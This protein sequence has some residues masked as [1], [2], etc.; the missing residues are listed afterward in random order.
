M[1]K[2]EE[3]TVCDLYDLSKYVNENN[4][5]LKPFLQNP[6]DIDKIDNANLIED[7]HT[8]P[9]D[10]VLTLTVD[11]SYGAASMR[12]AFQNVLDNYNKIDMISMA[13]RGITWETI[14]KSQR[15]DPNC[16]KLI[17]KAEMS[18]EK[19][20]N[21]RIEHGMLVKKRYGEKSWSHPGNSLI[22]IPA[23]AER[24]ISFFIASLHFGH[25][26][27]KKIYSVLRRAEERGVGKG[28][29]VSVESGGGGRQ[30][31]K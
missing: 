25:P 12:S 27:H 26:G 19:S 17:R 2:L 24:L 30:Q 1:P 22:V 21:Y 29:C 13:S 31:A 3:G 15:N 20:C 16:I 14:I 11:K 23:K 4:E 18:H 28:G 7:I 5:C 9:Y 6:K 10:L 8:L